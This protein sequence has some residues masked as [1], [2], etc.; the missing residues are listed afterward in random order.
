[1]LLFCGP[2]GIGKRLTARWYAAWLNCEQPGDEPCWTCPSC[3][4]LV[5]GRHPDYREV[6][7]RTITA[8]G[9][10]SRKPEITIG[11][12]VPRTGD[13][14]EPLGAWLEH[15][16]RF[17]R[18]VGVID[19]AQALHP[20]A[21]NAF[22]KILEAPPPYA[23]IVLIAP[24]P[25]EL[26]ATVVSR[27]VRIDFAPLETSAF[28]DLAPHP[29]LRM[30]QIGHLLEARAGRDAFDELQARVASYVTAL[31]A[32]LEQAL[33]A[34]DA[35]EKAWSNSE[36][37]VADLLREHLRGDIGLAP[38]RHW[39]VSRCEEAMEVYANP[40]LAVLRLTLDLRRSW[41]P[42]R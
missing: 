18:R 1:M 35:L 4:S 13:E 28:S 41:G 33:E 16:P 21:A 42:V 19:G 36:Q 29:G 27:S 8:S 30:G 22:L 26:L 31:S 9:K 12:L 38:D 40:S 6:A 37:G 5:A 24:S 2:D 15:R 20:A 25:Q 10:I 14:G 7:P 23:S 17:K 39:A 34:A 11:Q 32:D 3:L